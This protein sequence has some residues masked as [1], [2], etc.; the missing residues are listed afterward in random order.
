MP[1]E[2]NQ[3]H[4]RRLCIVR[5]TWL[6]GAIH[7]HSVVWHYGESRRVRIKPCRN[8]SG[9]CAAAAAGSS[10]NAATSSKLIF[11]QIQQ[12]P[13][14]QLVLA[15]E[16]YALHRCCYARHTQSTSAGGLRVAA[17]KRFAASVSMSI[18]S[19][20]SPISASLRHLQAKTRCCTQQ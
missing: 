11:L 13:E 7:M 19:P 16:D 5:Q 10:A 1:I 2:G 4:T 12:K 6:C 8:K 18:T 3:T 14:A 20:S 9:S 17:H 15:A